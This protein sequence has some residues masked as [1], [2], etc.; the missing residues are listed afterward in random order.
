MNASLTHFAF[1]DC[2]HASPSR[3]STD[4]R[5]ESAS[6]V[7]GLRSWMRPRDRS[8]LRLQGHLRILD[9]ADV[10]VNGSDSTCHL[11]HSTACLA[12]CF[13]QTRFRRFPSGN[14]HLCGNSGRRTWLR[15]TEL[16]RC[17]GRPALSEPGSMRVQPQQVSVL[18]LSHH[19][20]SALG[21][22]WFVVPARR[23]AGPE[24]MEE[25]STQDLVCC[26]LPKRQ[27]PWATACG[28]CAPSSSRVTPKGHEY[29]LAPTTSG[30]LT[31]W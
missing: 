22:I 24:E 15:R 25:I 27:A 10:Q 8:M 20:A 29:S 11:D 14:R 2:L 6:S 17:A 7:V 18:Q 4:G 21:H 12:V 16:H 19:R 13:I 31:I 28:D 1:R 26:E 30:L 3:V 23:R 9:I 5:S